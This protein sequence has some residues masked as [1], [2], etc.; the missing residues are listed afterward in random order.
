[1]GAASWAGSDRTSASPLSSWILETAPFGGV[2]KRDVKCEM[3]PGMGGQRVSGTRIESALQ[4]RVDVAI[5]ARARHDRCND[6][7][8]ELRIG[9]LRPGGVLS[10]G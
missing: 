8:P 7:P 2:G 6:P 10:V 4:D 9:F 1:M 5:R 3:R